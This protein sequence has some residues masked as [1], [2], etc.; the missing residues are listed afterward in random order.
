LKK[1]QRILLSIFRIK[2]LFNFFFLRTATGQ[3]PD[4]NLDIFS[5]SDQKILSKKDHEFE[6][7]ESDQPI[8][9]LS[10]TQQVKNQLLFC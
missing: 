7:Q 2:A 1:K 8:L 3:A 6:F 9:H 10:K 4:K 5:T